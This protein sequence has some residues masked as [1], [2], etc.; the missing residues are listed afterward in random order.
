MRSVGV[1]DKV[2]RLS[3]ELLCHHQINTPS[4]YPAP[5]EL[6][7]PGLISSHLLIQTQLESS[8]A[9][10]KSHTVLSTVSQKYKPHSAHP[11]LGV[12]QVT[13]RFIYRVPKVQTSRCSAQ[14]WHIRS[15][16]TSYLPWPR[17]THTS[18]LTPKHYTASPNLCSAPLNR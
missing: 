16:Q 10:P 17:R 15:H 4:D 11:K 3:A 7:A 5:G 2:L 8:S 14:T 1:S 12:S 9:S 6:L 13:H 18:L